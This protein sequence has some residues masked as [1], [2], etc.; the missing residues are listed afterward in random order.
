M[1]VIIGGEAAR[2]H[3]RRQDRNARHEST[4]S[5]LIV[6]H[7]SLASEACAIAARDGQS[8]ISRRWNAR[9]LLAI[10]MSLECLSCH[11]RRTVWIVI[12][13]VAPLVGTAAANP[14]ATPPEIETIR[15]Y[16]QQAIAE[17]RFG[18]ATSLYQS[19]IERAPRDLHALREGGRAAHAD[20]DFATAAALLGRAAAITT[21]SDPELRYLLG[22]ALWALGREGEA[23]IAY[24]RAQHEIGSTPTERLPRLWL[25]RILGRLGDRKAAD[26]IYEAMAITSPADPEVALAHAEMH[27]SVGNW[28]RAEETIERFLYV[29]PTHPRAREMLAW[30][31]E[32]QGQIARELELRAALASTSKDARPVRDYGRALERS[33]DWAAALKTYRRALRLSGGADD[34]DLA[35]A[36]RRM[37]Q[38]MSIEVAA[39]ATAKSD[40]A[41]GAVGAF[42]GV[43]LPFGRAHHLAMGAAHERV[44]KEGEEATASELFVAV[45][46]R[47]TATQVVGGARMGMTD[48]VHGTST[49]PGAFAVLRHALGRHL[50]LGADAELDAVWRE[51]PSATL[52]GGSSDSATAH[53]WG[54][55]AGRR[56]VVDSGAQVRRLHLGSEQMEASST[57]LFV[58]GGADLAVWRDFSAQA[59]GEVLDETLLQPAFLASSVVVSYRHYETYSSSTAM[60][61]ERLT[62]AE[63]ASI[64]EASLTVR[65]AALAG[66]LAIEART[67]LGY[68]WARELWLAR[69]GLSLW[70]AAGSASRISLTFDLAKESAHAIEGKR[71]SGGMAYHVDL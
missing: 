39:G 30:I 10:F 51:T 71:L 14:T 35:I 65:R 62:L 69:G 36:Q 20:R 15:A 47:D 24:A 26:A 61:S 7:T 22:E 4:S 46:M 25:A 11:L 67:G 55:G 56:I 43:A 60:F 48:S 16:A 34:H 54:F 12:T 70:I 29:R 52:L 59:A 1:V 31:T 38:R 45:S 17:G 37:A 3:A 42:T 6:S 66:R 64:D 28:A 5:S 68:D 53:V 2:R 41:A 50:Q 44:F 13:S 27:A 32:A 57:Q 63:R 49:K 8:E 21:S 9:C 18:A 19:L 58:W 33:G 23:R 40:P